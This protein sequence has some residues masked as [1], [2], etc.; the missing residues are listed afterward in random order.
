M[1]HT[2]GVS[3]YLGSIL[4]I[5]SN[6]CTI[7]PTGFRSLCVLV[8]RFSL[9]FS[10]SQKSLK[11]HSL[12][13]HLKAVS[14]EGISVY[15]WGVYLK[16]SPGGLDLDWA[17]SH[18]FPHFSFSSWESPL[19]NHVYAYLDFILCF[20][21]IRLYSWCPSKITKLRTEEMLS[22]WSV[23]CIHMRT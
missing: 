8:N 10:T 17:S 16:S 21:Q 23:C 3:S 1:K 4:C 19:I 22:G 15:F 9:H 7:F 6:P 12:R 14:R 2:V 20:W 11:L 5:S 13:P 18:N